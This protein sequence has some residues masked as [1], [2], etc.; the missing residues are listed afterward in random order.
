MS[1]TTTTEQ[2]TDANIGEILLELRKIKDERDE[3]SQRDGALA[4]REE[5]IKRT[6][7][8][9]HE[10]TGLT[11]LANHG[12]VVS[13]DPNKLRTKYEPA[14]WDAIMKWAID[15]GFGYIVQRRLTDAKVIDLIQ[16]GVA[17][18]DGLTTEAFTYVSIR[19]K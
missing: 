3:L 5:S 17:L 10:Q 6:L 1:T 7:I 9:F 13:F 4:T 2:A 11:Q 15:N 14:K 16:Q 8:G 12:L 19:R 18:P